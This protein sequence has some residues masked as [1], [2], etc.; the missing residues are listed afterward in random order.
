[1]T[2]RMRAERSRMCG[3]AGVG[4]IVGVQT[5]FGWAPVFGDAVNGFTAVQPTE[6]AAWP[7]F[8]SSSEVRKLSVMR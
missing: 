7:V 3:V 4:G 6:S 1:M 5:I 2:K 8:D